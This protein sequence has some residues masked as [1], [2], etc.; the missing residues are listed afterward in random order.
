MMSSTNNRIVFVPGCLLCPSFQAVKSDD[1]LAWSKKI[2][3]F[4]LENGIEIIAMPC[5]EVTFKGY[6]EGVSRLPH[7]I[8]YYE[9]KEGFA[10]HCERLGMFVLNQ[11][12]ELS[13]AGYDIVAIV[14]I[15]HSPTCAVN[16]M[17]THHGTL[18]RRGIFL[19]AIDKA[20]VRLH[21]EIP[22]MGINRRFPNKFIRELSLLL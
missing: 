21:L 11:I 17:Y 1:N 5:P 12:D 6:H 19:S 13:Q 8:D 3:P 15:E 4:F 14:G 16:Y 10:E 22:I 7:G 9:K 2:V 18:K 20:L